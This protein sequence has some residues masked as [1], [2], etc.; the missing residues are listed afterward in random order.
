VTVTTMAPAD[1]NTGVGLVG[2]LDGNIEKGWFSVASVK[3]LRTATL[4]VLEV[5]SGWESTDLRSRDGNSLFDRFRNLRRNA[6][7]DDSITFGGV[8][9]ILTCS[10]RRPSSGR[11]NRRG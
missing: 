2:F 5:E 7:S 1:L 8:G 11:I 6:Y 10:R 9:C 4:K 3:A